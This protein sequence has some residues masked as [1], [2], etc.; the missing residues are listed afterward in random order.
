MREMTSSRRLF[1]RTEAERMLPLV[2]SI[3][4]DLVGNYH[5][6]AD[7]LTLYEQAVKA[8]REGAAFPVTGETAGSAEVEIESLHAR[9]LGNLHELERL[10]LVCRD[11]D[12]G[13]VEFPGGAG[14]L[15]WSFDD[16]RVS[17][18]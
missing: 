14:P 3:V 5:A 6:L 7:R 2:R 16:E 4:R 1:T 18:N 10:G 17:E 12:R 15:T 13:V 11:P 9:L 8:R